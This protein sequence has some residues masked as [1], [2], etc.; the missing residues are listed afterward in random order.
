MTDRL[1]PWARLVRPATWPLRLRV[2]TAFLLAAA[3]A[4]TLLGVFVQVRVAEALEH[5]THDLLEAEAAGLVAAPETERAARVESMTGD[6]Y[7]QLLDEDGRPVASSPLVAGPLVSTADLAGLPPR[8]SWSAERVVSVLDDDAAATG[9]RHVE[10]EAVT[11]LVTH[12]DLQLVAVATSREDTD[13]A[14]NAV[15][16]QLVTGLPLALVVAGALGYLAAGAGLRPIER[17]RERAE[18]ISDRSSGERLPVPPAR[19][20]LHRLV[21]TL[22]A[23]LDRLDDGLRRQRR[24]VAEASH[25]LRTPLALLRTEVD[26]ALARERTPEELSAALR[27]IGQETTR[28]TVLAESLLTLAAADEGNLALTRAPV[29]LRDFALE[30]AARFSTSAPAPIGTTGD[31]AVVVHADRNRLDQ[32]LSNLVDNALRHGAPPVG[33]DVLLDGDHAR[34]TVADHGAGFTVQEPFDRFVSSHRSAGLG[35]AIVREIV[36][37]HGGTTRIVRRNGTTSVVVELP[38]TAGRGPGG[39]ELRP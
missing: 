12:A 24:F 17:V 3:L 10:H 22:N 38:T 33:I 11:L 37:A 8:G 6:V 7:A 4:L 16:V 34:L 5:R 19:D 21:V 36:A 35:L 13:E 25:E 14:L 28:L 27:S 1:P 9:D 26:L 23:M 20:E 32:A 39:G 29:D 2:A 30:V 15:R 31:T 18:R